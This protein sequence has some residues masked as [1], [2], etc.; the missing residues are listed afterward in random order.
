MRAPAEPVLTPEDRAIW[1]AYE[2][3]ALA[4]SRT[5]VHARRVEA[6]RRIAADFHAANPNGYLAW[7]AG[8]DSTALVHLVRVDRGLDVPAMSIKDDLD[9]PGEEEYLARWAGEWGVR[10]EIVRPAFSLQGFLRDR[11]S[12][13]DPSEDMHGRA[14][15]LSR[16]G[17]YPLI[18]EYVARTGQRAVY[19]G[20]RAEESRGRARNLWTHGTCYERRDGIR[21]C[22]PLVRWRGVDVFSYLLARGIEPLAIYRCAAFHGG[23]PSRVRKS[24]WVPGAHTSRGGMVWLKRYW[25][26]LYRQL[27]ELLPSAARFA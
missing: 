12:E 14:A 7:S 15:A 10:L 13:L 5:L 24:W 22:Q 17:F 3:Q 4:H 11:G 9:F 2:R 20:L 21:V 23:D 18:D 27:E 6:A 26:S 8:K 1:S 16:E 25:P 19:L